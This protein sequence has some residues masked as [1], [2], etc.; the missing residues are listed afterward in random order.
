[1]DDTV[2]FLARG[3][4]GLAVSRENV[5]RERQAL[6]MEKERLDIERAKAEQAQRVA[7]LALIGFLASRDNNNGS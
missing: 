6:A 4:Q 2:R 7:K 3:N 5:L 1:M